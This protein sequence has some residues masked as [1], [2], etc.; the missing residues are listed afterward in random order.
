MIV[1]RTLFR[2]FGIPIRPS[3]TVLVPVGLLALQ[4]G[5]W[6]VVAGL[7]LFASVLLHELGHALVARRFGID[8]TSIH[9]HLLGGVAMMVDMPREPRHEALIAA[10]GPA[11]SFALAG[12]FGA[13]ALATGASLPSFPGLGQSWLDL[14]AYAAVLNLGMALFNL[15]PA[16]PMDG[17]RILRAAWAHRRGWLRATRASAKISRVFAALFVAAGLAMGAWSLALIGGLLFFLSGSEERA[18]AQRLRGQPSDPGAPVGASRLVW[19]RRPEGWVLV[20][21]PSAPRPPAPSVAPR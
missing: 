2:A 13:L 7:L 11:V 4:F 17:G 20:R 16:L 21:V 10:A 1:G 8:V 3:V 14:F 6:G 18:V 15:I 19:L 5:A 12:A 9:L